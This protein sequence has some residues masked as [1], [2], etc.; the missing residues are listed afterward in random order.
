VQATN[1][2]QITALSAFLFGFK[3]KKSVLLARPG[4]KLPGRKGLDTIKLATSDQYVVSDML[5]SYSCIQLP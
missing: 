2:A 4:R 3:M 5:F 1:F